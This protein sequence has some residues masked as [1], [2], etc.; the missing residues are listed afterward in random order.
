MCTNVVTATYTL[1]NWTC[2]VHVDITMSIVLLFP[3][4]HLSQDCIDNC[5]RRANA[6]SL[7]ESLP[8]LN[9][10]LLIYLVRFLKVNGWSPTFYQCHKKIICHILFHY[11]AICDS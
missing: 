4:L 1:N 6:I 10:E 9:K 5:D 8:D 3:R 11:V 7:I 2:S